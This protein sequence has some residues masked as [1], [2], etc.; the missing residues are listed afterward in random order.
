MFLFSSRFSITALTLLTTVSCVSIDITK[1]ETEKADD[2]KYQAPNSKFQEISTDGI[3]NGWR[4]SENG[5]TISFISDC[6]KNYD[7]TLQSI[8]FGVVSGLQNITLEKIEKKMYNGRASRKSHYTGEVDGIPT[9]IS[10]MTFKK[11]GCI[12]VI[13][14]IGVSQHY[15]DNLPDFDVFLQRFEAP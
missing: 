10:L 3:D 14:Y 5:N 13:T 8:E 2:I 9:Q 15:Q 1:N 12:F 6:Q 4:H 7:P 11:N